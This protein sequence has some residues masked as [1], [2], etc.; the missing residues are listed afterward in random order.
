MI[1]TL[2][3]D[4]VPSDIYPYFSNWENIFRERMKDLSL[5][6]LNWE[7]PD[8][9]M[10]AFNSPS[11]YVDWFCYHPVTPEPCRDLSFYIREL[12]ILSAMM[13]PTM[14]VELGTNLGF[15]TFLLSKLNPGAKLITVDIGELTKGPEPELVPTGF[16]ARMNNVEYTQIFGNSWK[17]KIPEP[18]DFCF[19]D[20][21]HSYEAVVRDSYWA[22]EHRN[23]QKYIIVWHDFA[24]WDDMYLGTVRAITDFS[25]E[26]GIIV[27]RFED[28][29]TV[30]HYKGL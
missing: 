15:G 28:S 3:K 26:K 20:A 13:N 19:I 10:R 22:W 25:N 17:T 11:A 30:W 16:L 29:G 8:L 1:C 23:P 6:P 2:S 5:V 9:N 24:P 4:V 7:G 27:Y 12:T 18:F 21:D 14:I